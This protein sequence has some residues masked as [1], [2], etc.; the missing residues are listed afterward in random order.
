MKL[1]VFI[2]TLACLQVSA[3]V[4]SQISL[5]EKNASLSKVINMIQQQSGYSFFY[6][7]SLLRD[8]HISAD[9]KNATL[10][11]ALNKVL[12]EQQLTYEIID[13]SVVIKK[14]EISF[15]DQL[16]NAIKA[17]DVHG[18]VVDEKGEPLPGA[19]ILVKGRNL[20]TT[21]SIA[22]EFS[23]TGIDEK[24]EITISSVGYKMITIKAAKEMGTIRM[25]VLIS[26]LDQVQV[27]AYGTTTKRL[28]T[29]D[30]TT[31]KADDIAN[32]PISN[33]LMV[34]EGNVPGLNLKQASGQTGSGVNIQIRGYNSIQQGS[35]PLYIVD[36]VPYPGSSIG[37]FSFGNGGQSPLESLNPS[38]IESIDVLKDADATAIYGS[39]GANGVILITTKKGKAGNTKFNATVY[40]GNADVSRK[41]DLLNTPQYIQMRQEAF[42]NDGITPTAVNAPDLVSWDNNR[43]TDWQKMLIGGTA[44]HTN[45]N[46]S[47]SGGSENTQYVFSM[48]YNRQT[49]V[50]PGSE[51]ETRGVG[52]FSINNKSNNGKFKM[53]VSG[54]YSVDD[55]ELPQ[56]DLTRYILLA[57]N[58]PSL[59]DQNGNLNWSENGGS[60]TNPLSFLLKKNTLKTD[61]FLGN[62]SLSYEVIP[63][64]FLKTTA[65]Y[66]LIQLGYISLTPLASQDPST[67]RTATA[68]FQDVTG[69]NWNIEPQLEYIVSLG[70]GKLDALFGTSIE[71][72]VQNVNNILATGFPSD[73]VLTAAEFATTVTAQT[74]LVEY[75]YQALFARLN[76]AWDNKY[77]L[78][79]TARRDGSSRFGSDKQV[80]NF[81]AVGAAWIFSDENFIKKSVPFL[82]FGKLRGS[83][84]VT[85]N[86][87]IGDYQYLDNYSS[88]LAYQGQVSYT[89]SR[90]FNADYSWEITKKL[91]GAI[92]LG[93]LSNRVNL[94]V[95]Y[96]RDRSGNQLVSYTLPG[97]TGFTSILA[98]FPAL[99]QNSGWEYTLATT[100]IH[101]AKFTWST[102]AN[103]TVLE[104]KLLAFPNLATSSYASSLV[105]GQPT[106]IQKYLVA[107]GVNPTTGLY[108]FNGTS[109]PTNETS[110]TNTTPKFYGGI[111]NS[112]TYGNF[113]LSFLFQF[114]KQNGVS[115][116]GA[117]PYAPGV[118]TTGALSNQPASVLA[119][120][121]APGDVTSIQKFTTS[122]TAYT[123]LAYSDASV[124]DASFIRLKNIAFDYRLPANLMH[125]IKL[126]SCKVFI[127][128]QNLLTITRYKGLDP[129]TATFNGQGFSA[130]LVLPTLKTLVIGIQTS[131]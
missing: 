3:K 44:H 32:E 52:R 49:S 111:T 72:N 29:G 89:P 58:A 121:Q 26:A 83:Y 116:F 110:V 104:N 18:K 41:L 100:N 66:N 10:A 53:S 119:R 95:A 88:A 82:S 51:A 69:K 12:A 68:T 2:I 22:G 14:K 76:Y 17:I 59:Y 87:Q 120:W 123:Y 63:G 54:S 23:L 73:N 106:T 30:I 42:K 81:G 125:R 74:S 9:L 98:N 117:F 102:S 91:E 50:L 85:G 21:T 118:L 128:G 11:D 45:A 86:D 16:I 90:L 129:E 97:Q 130:G 8:I 108:Q 20:L 79:I 5:S 114:V 46:A 13:K 7:H 115:E 39:R 131:L 25:E 92:E 99:V 61:N 126:N 60:F 47:L 109:I 4:Y 67:S 38:D 103:L 15:L 78:N 93:A 62:L 71:D 34:L 1:T 6:K 122:N 40:Q 101:A 65:G 84:G 112:F 105:I 80:S 48:N 124:T 27:I 35:A 96:F 127:Q 113:D 75:R 36:G 94:T 28:N 37:T 43:Y 57:P 19:T 70:K 33:P 77:L 55:N 107:Q 31:I 56:I 64:L 24:A